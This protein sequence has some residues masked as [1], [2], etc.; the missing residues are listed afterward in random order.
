MPKPTGD[1]AVLYRMAEITAELTNIARSGKPFTQCEAQSKPLRRE[2]A[3]LQQ[4]M[5]G[6]SAGPRLKNGRGP[7]PG[8]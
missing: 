4:R 5:W 7:A 6:T 3:E 2:L 1:G 8:K